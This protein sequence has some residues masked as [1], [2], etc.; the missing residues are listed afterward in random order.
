MVMAWGINL[1]ESNFSTINL[2]QIELTWTEFGKIDLL[3]S[4]PASK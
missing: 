3:H 2:V 4:L 1:N